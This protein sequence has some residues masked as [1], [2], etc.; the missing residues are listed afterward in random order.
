MKRPLFEKHDPHAE[1]S[2]KISDK[3]VKSVREEIENRSINSQ[4]KNK[5][6]GNRASAPQAPEDAYGNIVTH[7][8]SL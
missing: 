4:R 2:K 8:M 6:N 3:L 5:I 1:M 7:E